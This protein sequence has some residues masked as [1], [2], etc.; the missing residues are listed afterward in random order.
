MSIS[1]KVNVEHWRAENLA[2]A[3]AEWKSLTN[4]EEWPEEEHQVRFETL[5][6][7]CAYTNPGK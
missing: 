2:K 5:L 6:R 3:K 4:K 1:K 7:L